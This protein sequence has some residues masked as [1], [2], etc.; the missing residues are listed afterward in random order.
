MT[1]ELKKSDQKQMSK[2]IGGRHKYTLLYKISRDGC[3]AV[4]FHSNC[5][6]KGAT[7][8]VLYNSNG[9]VYGGYTS[10]SWRSAGAYG[11]D[12]KAFLFRLYQNGT[13][14]P[15]QF[16]VATG[17]NAIYDVANY[18]PI[19]GAHDLNAFT[20]TVAHDGTCFPLNGGTAFGTS[21]TMKGENANTICNGN[22]KVTDLEVYLVEG[23]I[24]SIKQNLLKCTNCIKNSRNK[25][26]FA[27]ISIEFYKLKCSR[28]NKI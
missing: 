26:S 13:F 25:C 18:G 20:G 5:N 14:K 15:V 4:A 21:Y 8:T 3:N 11:T 27:V 6:N 23:M 9:S 10:I 28:E 16:P 12:N 7:V 17:I 22:L 24:N 1:T 19:F 2:W